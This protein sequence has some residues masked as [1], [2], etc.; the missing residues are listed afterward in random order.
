VKYTLEPGAAGWI[1]TNYAGQSR[2]F[3]K[4]WLALA[5]IQKQLG[6]HDA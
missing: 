3:A 6:A 2:T 5:Y 1:V 4:L